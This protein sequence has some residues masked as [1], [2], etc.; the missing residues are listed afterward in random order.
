[1]ATKRAY[2]RNIKDRDLIKKFTL[3]AAASNSTTSAALDLGVRTAAGSLPSELELVLEIPALSATI[4]PD[5]RTVTLTIEESDAENFGSTTTTGTLVLTGAGGVGIAANE[6]RV[7][8]SPH[9]KRY[10]RGKVAF[11]A[12]TTDGSALEA[13]FSLRA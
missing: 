2:K 4:A 12:S 9:S 10:V 1:M 11:G 6:L 7:A 5:T 3:P 13:E 8:L